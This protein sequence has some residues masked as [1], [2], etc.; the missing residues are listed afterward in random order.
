VAA[1]RDA[2]PA[3]RPSLAGSRLV[4]VRDAL[5]RGV[6]A[7]LAIAGDGRSHWMIAQ[8]DC[9][10]DKDPVRLAFARPSTVSAATMT[11]LHPME[12]TTDRVVCAAEAPDIERGTAKDLRKAAPKR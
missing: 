7:M 10:S 12:T 3:C 8:N 9:R 11:T 4:P 6:L 2:A 1:S 5:S